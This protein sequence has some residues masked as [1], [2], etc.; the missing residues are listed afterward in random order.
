[1]ANVIVGLDAPLWPEEAR[2]TKMAV[3]THGV[4]LTVL[5]DSAA[6]H[7]TVDVHGSPREGD[8]LIVDALV[9]MAVTVATFTLE[10]VTVR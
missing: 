5:A 4:M 8:L 6:F 7:V 10:W 3:D 1:M 2:L 9:G